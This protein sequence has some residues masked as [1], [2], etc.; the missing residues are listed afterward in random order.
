[1]DIYFGQHE[2]WYAEIQSPWR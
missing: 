1:M 2:R